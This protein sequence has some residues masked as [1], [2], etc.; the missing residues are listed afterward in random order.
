MSLSFV[1][2]GRSGG[3]YRQPF[4][5]AD[6]IEVQLEPLRIS[7]YHSRDIIYVARSTLVEHCPLHDEVVNKVSCKH[8]Q[9]YLA[10]SSR[11]SY[12]IGSRGQGSIPVFSQGSHII[13]VHEIGQRFPRLHAQPA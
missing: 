12:L 6:V 2:I 13:V 8:W 7:S 11:L 4:K 9:G 5:V 1:I 10:W 3:S